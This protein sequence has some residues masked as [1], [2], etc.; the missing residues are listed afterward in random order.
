MHV[1]GI[2]CLNDVMWF[3][4]TVFYVS[5][6][7][8]VRRFYRTSLKNMK[9]ILHLSFVK[10]FQPKFIMDKFLLYSWTA[11]IFIWSLKLPV[12]LWIMEKFKN[13]QL[14]CLHI[15]YIKIG[16]HKPNRLMQRV[17][18]VSASKIYEKYVRCSIMQQVALCY[19]TVMMQLPR[20]PPFQCC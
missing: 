10:C 7:S 18:T 17:V 6:S 2:L 12:F 19:M 1:T 11:Y 14:H 9:S 20:A 5:I 4:K 16:M 15:K 3:V 13:S 8:N